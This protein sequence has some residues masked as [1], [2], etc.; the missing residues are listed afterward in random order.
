[1]LR[2]I[3]VYSFQ[4]EIG[5]NIMLGGRYLQ[6]SDIKGSYERTRGVVI[7]IRTQAGW[8]RLSVYTLVEVFRYE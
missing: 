5:D 2:N 7:D 1:M 4:L 3:H 8:S 6:V